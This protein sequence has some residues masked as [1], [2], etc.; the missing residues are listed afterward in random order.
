MCSFEMFLSITCFPHRQFLF[1]ALN[2]GLQGSCAASGFIFYSLYSLQ[3]RCH[4][5][6]HHLMKDTTNKNTS[7]SCLSPA[8]TCFILGA[9]S[10]I[11]STDRTLGLQYSNSK[12]IH[13]EASQVSGKEAKLKRDLQDFS[14]HLI[15]NRMWVSSVKILKTLG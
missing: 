7:F 10:K 1:D 2:C 9:L 14:L 8:K 12:T 15:L 3:Q 6:H 13:K 11:I 5:G 4:V